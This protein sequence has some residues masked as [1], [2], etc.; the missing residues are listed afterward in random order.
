MEELE[1]ADQQAEEGAAQ[2]HHEHAAHVLHV[3]GF[4]AFGFRGTGA[5]LPPG[6]K[7]VGWLWF[8]RMI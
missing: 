5:A 1:D 7:R 6:L 3:Q 2:Q 8:K 4:H